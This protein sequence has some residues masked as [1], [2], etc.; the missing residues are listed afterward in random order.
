MNPFPRT[1][2]RLRVVS[3]IATVG[4][5]GVDDFHFL[6]CPRC[7]AMTSGVRTR[8]EAISIVDCIE[9]GLSGLTNELTIWNETTKMQYRLDPHPEPLRQAVDAVK[10]GGVEATVWEGDVLIAAYEPKVGVTYLAG[11]CA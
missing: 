5:I 10:R 3:T 6:E 7:R 11:R 9:C 8:D 4:D 1:R 2:R